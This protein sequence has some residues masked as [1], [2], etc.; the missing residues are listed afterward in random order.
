MVLIPLYLGDVLGQQPHEK[1]RTST[2][3]SAAVSKAYCNTW[4]DARTVIR[5][6]ESAGYLLGEPKRILRSNGHVD[7]FIKSFIGPRSVVLSVSA[8]KI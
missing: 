6:M 4:G 7:G 8:P 5:G 1:T 3:K 2:E